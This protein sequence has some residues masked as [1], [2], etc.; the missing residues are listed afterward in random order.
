MTRRGTV[1]LPKDVR[2]GLDEN[3]VFE[4]SRRE[5]GTIELHPR[6]LVD[7][8]QRWFWS[9]RWQAMER[10]ADED[11]REG[12]IRRFDSGGEFLSH[13]ARAAEE[14]PGDDAPAS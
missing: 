14:N 8:S 12:R 9:A 6:A 2:E 13:L 3:T 5:D 1:T 7:A 4:I 11:I 10:E